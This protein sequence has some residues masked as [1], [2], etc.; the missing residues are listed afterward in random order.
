MSSWLGVILIVLILLGILTFYLRKHN[1]LPA[2]LSDYLSSN[3]DKQ[4]A[5]IKFQTGQEIEKS[6]ELQAILEAKQELMQAKARNSALRR[7]IAEV[8]ETNVVLIAKRYNN[9]K[10]KVKSQ[11]S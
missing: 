10:D 9:G 7:D 6:K 3:S 5:K 4:I 2:W 8:N 1:F 11:V